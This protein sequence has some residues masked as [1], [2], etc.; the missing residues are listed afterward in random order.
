MFVGGNPYS[1][2]LQAEDKD[3]LVSEY[4]EA[5]EVRTKPRPQ[6][7]N[8]LSGEVR[9]GKVYLKWDRGREPD[10]ANY[11][12]YEKKFFGNEKI[13]DE[14]TNSFTETAPPKGKNK[15][16]LVTAVDSDDLESNPSREIT[17]TGK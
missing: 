8:G 12:I 10:I 4:S 16:Y 6:T 13:A 11:R 5:I 17:V 3:G 2:K 9:S 1:Y 14:K 7:P 15:T